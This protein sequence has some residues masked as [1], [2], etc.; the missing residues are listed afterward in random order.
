[1]A[2]F[3]YTYTIANGQSANA[4][5]VMKNYNDAKDFLQANAIPAADYPSSN[6]CII[7]HNGTQTIP[8]NSATALSWTNVIADGTGIWQGAGNPTDFKTT[9]AGWYAIYCEI[10]SSTFGAVF[11]ID[12]V[13]ITA[14]LSHTMSGGFNSTG[15]TTATTVIKMAASSTFRVRVHQTSG[16]SVN[17]T[18]PPL[19][20]FQRI[21]Y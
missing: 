4:V 13:D 18:G 8:N 1:M 10:F 20:I 16:A 15:W 17:I 3:S 12:L 21:G 6:G 7:Y 19:L 14:A 5:V 11:A 2:S 9:T